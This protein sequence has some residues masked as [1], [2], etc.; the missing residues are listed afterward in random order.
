VRDVARTEHE[1]P[2]TRDDR[3]AGDP[4][5]ELALE[6]VEP[7]VLVVVNVERRAAAARRGLLGDHHATAGAGAVGL[8]RRQPPEEPEVLALVGSM[9]DGCEGVLRRSRHRAS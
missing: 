7:L 6:D 1:G 4:D 9:G 3:L 2:G 8:D 5:R